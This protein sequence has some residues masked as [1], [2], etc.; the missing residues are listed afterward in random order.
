MLIPLDWETVQRDLR[1]MVRQ[2]VRG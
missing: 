1:D 2:F